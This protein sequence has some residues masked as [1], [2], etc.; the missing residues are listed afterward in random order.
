MDFDVTIKIILIKKG[1]RP[2][3]IREAR[4]LSF[5]KTKAAITHEAGTINII[6]I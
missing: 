4:S 2:P 1:I 6:K 5:G 3:T